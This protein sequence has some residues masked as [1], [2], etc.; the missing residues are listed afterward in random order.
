[1]RTT[2][3]ALLCLGSTVFLWGLQPLILKPVLAV[4][5]VGL[6]AFVRSAAA[7]TL[8]GIVALLS[9]RRREPS[10]IPGRIGASLALWLL[11]GGVGLGLCNVLWNASLTRT[12]IGASSILQLGGTLAIACYGLLVLREPFGPLR[13]GGLLLS[14][15]GLVLVSWN[16]ESLGALVASRYFQGNLFALASGLGWGV[17]AIAQKVSVRERSSVQVAVSIFA[18]SALTSGAAALSGPAMV[19]PFSPALLAALALT[20]LLGMGLGNVLFAEAMRTLTASVGAVALAAS[21][22][23]SLLSAVLFLHEPISVYLMIGAPLTCAG[24]AAAVVSE[25]AA[26]AP[27]SA[28]PQ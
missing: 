25:S 28:K 23:V 9:R 12:T 14:L 22:L 13:A 6:A 2:V 15:A 26:A 7:L 18:V 16:G 24:V 10:A 21:P 8:F 20:G 3:R 19:A 17:C 4:Y 5:S 11:T 27:A 1:V